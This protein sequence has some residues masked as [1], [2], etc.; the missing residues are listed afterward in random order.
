LILLK[1]NYQVLIPILANS[2]C[3]EDAINLVKTVSEQPYKL[4]LVLN[5]VDCLHSDE[6]NL[7]K[8]LQLINFNK[9]L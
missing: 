9:L 7:E 5:R 1:K 8:S 2:A 3:D 6:N 4:Y